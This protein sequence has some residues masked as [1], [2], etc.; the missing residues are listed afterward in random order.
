MLRKLRPFFGLSLSASQVFFFILTLKYAR[1]TAMLIN[2]RLTTSWKDPRYGYL[3]KRYLQ[4]NRS[5]GIMH[6]DPMKYSVPTQGRSPRCSLILAAFSPVGSSS[7]S[8]KYATDSNESDLVI[9]C[10]LE[11]SRSNSSSFVS[12]K[13]RSSESFMSS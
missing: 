6:M 10:L 12:S 9:L 2:D 1:I 8:G 3:S 13:L 4:T 5:I 7:S 11:K